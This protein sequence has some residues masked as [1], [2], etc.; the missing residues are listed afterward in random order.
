MKE[1]PKIGDFI[2][3]KNR[4]LIRTGTVVAVAETGVHFLVEM[5]LTSTITRKS[6]RRIG[7]SAIIQILTKHV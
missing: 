4:G 6:L 5:S 1:R 2:E 7:L 3:F